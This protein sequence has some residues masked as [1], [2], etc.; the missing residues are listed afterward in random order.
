MFPW[1]LLFAFGRGRTPDL[2]KKKKEK[3]KE[4]KKSPTLRTVCMYSFI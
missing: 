2:E 1:T 3:K 4:E